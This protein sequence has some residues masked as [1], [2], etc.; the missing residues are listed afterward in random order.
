MKVVLEVC[1]AHSLFISPFVARVRSWPT[2]TKP[3]VICEPCEAPAM[4]RGTTFK[5]WYTYFLT[6]GPFLIFP[7]DSADPSKPE[8][9]ISYSFTDTECVRNL[10]RYSFVRGKMKRTRTRRTIEVPPGRRKIFNHYY[11]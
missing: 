6:G 11:V 8:I 4:V 10:Y 2:N 9:I 5:R 3:M 7:D 1:Q